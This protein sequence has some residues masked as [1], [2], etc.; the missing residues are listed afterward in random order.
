[1]T[2]PC[3]ACSV[4]ANVADWGRVQSILLN[5]QSMLPLITC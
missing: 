5:A 1:M 2:L 4:Y 3:F